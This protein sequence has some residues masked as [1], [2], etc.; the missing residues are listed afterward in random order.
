MPLI[1]EDLMAAKRLSLHYRDIKTPR[2]VLTNVLNSAT[3]HSF[4]NL[5]H[6]RNSSSSL[7]HERNWYVWISAHSVH[8]DETE[9][10][11]SPKSNDWN[12]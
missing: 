11:G 7:L 5:L 1:W 10:I 3:L 4:F 8:V 9:V 6:E 2:R 12:K